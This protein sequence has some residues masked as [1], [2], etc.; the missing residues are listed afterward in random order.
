MF[1][2]IN[3]IRCLTEFNHFKTPTTLLGAWVPLLNKPFNE[4]IRHS[5]PST[6]LECLRGAGNGRKD[7]L[8]DFSNGSL[9][10]CRLFSENFEN[11]VGEFESTGDKMFL[12]DF[13]VVFQNHPNQRDCPSMYR[14]LIKRSATRATELSNG[15]FIRTFFTSL[16]LKM[17]DVKTVFVQVFVRS[18]WS[19]SSLKNMCKK[20]EHVVFP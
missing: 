5:E 3:K 10:D 17:K 8:M 9:V 11:L 1:S 2:A 15:T 19:M 7:V 16:L 14:N 4:T 18:K 6:S 13:D 20:V 12:M